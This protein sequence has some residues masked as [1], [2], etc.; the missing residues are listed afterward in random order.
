MTVIEVARGPLENFPR[1][2]M[3]PSHFSNS[4]GAQP[5]CGRFNCQNERFFGS[6]GI[7]ALPANGCLLLLKTHI[8]SLRISRWFQAIINI[9][10]R[11]LKVIRSIR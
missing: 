6:G 8:F 11:V 3:A 2:P 4:R 5:I 1:A 10:M 7:M 9:I